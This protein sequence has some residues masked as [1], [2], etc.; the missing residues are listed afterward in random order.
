MKLENPAN[1][2]PGAE[3]FYLKGSENGVM[4][5]HGGGGGSTAD[6]RELGRYIHE[7]TG[8]SVL[9]PLLPGFGTVKEDL[10]NI[11]IDDWLNALKKW[12]TQFKSE[13]TNIF[14]LGHSMGG[15]LTLYLAGEFAAD[16]SGVVS[17]CAPIKLKGLLVKFVPFFKYFLKYYRQNDLKELARVTDGVW[18]GYEY[19]PLSIV[20]KFQK[21]IKYTK[22]QLHHISAPILIIQGRYDEFVTDWS[23]T[24]IYQN[25]SS[26]QKSIQWYETDHAILFAKQRLE[27]FKTIIDFLQHLKT[28]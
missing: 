15:V 17:I 24:Y 5:I 7:Q 28:I 22:K 4:L 8:F 16:V 11:Q 18:K 19:I 21:L 14:L 9:A 3:G 10:H 26:T 23:P 1:V 2:I 20:G 13:L 25:V 12:F 6:M 27:I